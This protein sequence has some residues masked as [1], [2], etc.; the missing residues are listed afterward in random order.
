MSG[1]GASSFIPKPVRF[2]GLVNVL[3]VLGQYWFQT[4]TLPAAK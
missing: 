1:L 2:E 3:R 4:V